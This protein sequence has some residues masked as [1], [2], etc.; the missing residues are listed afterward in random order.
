M[1][2][3]VEINDMSDKWRSKKSWREKIENPPPDLPKIVD[4]PASWEKQMG[5]RRV[6]VPTPLLV[7]QLIR[8]VKR[9][10]L[11][12]VDQIR[13]R[14]AADFKA[15]STCPMTTGIFLRI[16]S[17]AA[18]ED[19]RNGKKRVTPYWRV[20]KA[21]GGLNPK[22]PGGV[23]AQAAHLKEEGHCISPGKGKKP[24]LVKD[25]AKALVK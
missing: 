9:G 18:E 15:D 5:G 3:V 16:I 23:G 7:D 1:R 8:T 11:I 24:P 20:V 12:S 25:F 19:L 13:K 17:E 22:Y 6:L 21:D 14:L 4:V 10:K 2:K